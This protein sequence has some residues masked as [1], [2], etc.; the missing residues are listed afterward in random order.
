MHKAGIFD[1]NGAMSLHALKGHVAA[2]RLPN[3]DEGNGPPVLLMHGITTS[4]LPWRH[5]LPVLGAS[6]RVV[7]PA[8]LNCGESDQPADADVTIAGQSR[9]MLKMVDAHR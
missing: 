4:S 8:M 9:L 5:I 7:A 6:H 2:L 3:Q 1:C